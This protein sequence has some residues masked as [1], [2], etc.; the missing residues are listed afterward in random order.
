M[1]GPLFIQID[2]HRHLPKLVSQIYIFNPLFTPIFLQLD[3]KSLPKI[4]QYSKLQ[5]TAYVLDKITRKMWILLGNDLCIRDKFHVCTTCS[6]RSVYWR[7]NS[8]LRDISG[9]RSYIIESKCP[10]R[11]FRRVFL[12][13]TDCLRRAKTVCD[14]HIMSVTDNIILKEKIY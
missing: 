11:T 7:T 12:T 9:Q 1:N 8:N 2:W 13:D 5:K 10:P 3:H 14:R 6:G 4:A